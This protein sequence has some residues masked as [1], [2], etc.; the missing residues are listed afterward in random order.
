MYL[1]HNQHSCQ[2]TIQPLIKFE[3][4]YIKKQNNI[5]FAAPNHQP[6][7]AFIDPFHISLGPSFHPRAFHQFEVPPKPLD[8]CSEGEVAAG[9]ILRDFSILKIQ[10]TP[11]TIEI[12][13]YHVT[14]LYMSLNILA[15]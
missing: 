2:L 9:I 3:I 10:C 7:Y 13:V 15:L 6:I 11:F 4:T 14:N 5:I 1:S 12:H 8:V